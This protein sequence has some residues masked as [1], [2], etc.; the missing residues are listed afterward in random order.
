MR[1]AEVKA[2]L[3][4]GSEITNAK[5]AERISS[6][7]GTIFESD[8][9]SVVFGLT[10]GATVSFQFGTL[11]VEDSGGW[12]ANR[13]GRLLPPYLTRL[14]QRYSAYLQRPGLSRIPKTAL[15]IIAPPA[16]PSAAPPAAPTAPVPAVA[17][18]GVSRKSASPKATRKTAVRK[19]RS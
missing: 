6:K 12:M 3:L 2:Y 13:I 19:R 1:Q 16:T 9:E 8:T 18:K 7:Y 14:Q 17:A 10:G 4:K 5:V 15:P 11:L